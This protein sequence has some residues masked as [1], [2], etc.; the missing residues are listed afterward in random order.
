MTNTF[1]MNNT[2]GKNPMTFSRNGGRNRASSVASRTPTGPPTYNS[3]NNTLI[4]AGD[5]S[6]A[7][8]NGTL[9][10]SGA[11]PANGPVFVP[12]PSPAF[13][14][15]AVDPTTCAIV[16]GKGGVGKALRAIY[17]EQ[18]VQTGGLWAVVDMGTVAANKTN[19]WRAQIRFGGTIT[20][21]I[22]VKFAHF[23]LNNIPGGGQP[24]WSTHNANPYTATNQGK[25]TYWQFI[26]SAYT[27]DVG[28]YPDGDDQGTQPVGPFMEDLFDGEWHEFVWAYKTHSVGVKDGLARMWIDG[29]KIIDVSQEAVGVTPEGGFKQWCNQAMVDSIH[30]NI[31]TDAYYGPWFGGT[32]STL[33]T[34]DWH[35]ELNVGDG[36]PNNLDTFAWWTD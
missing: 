31:G 24:Q 2:N 16:T 25:L 10:D 36:D 21:E 1:I 8:M 9:A 4:F 29:T 18:N 20:E 28:T 3:L 30:T 6:I 11:T 19:Y 12:S 33:N 23:N 17:V 27:D 22:A 35:M 15:P 34:P 14:G 7:R 5:A 26:E 13:N 32:Q